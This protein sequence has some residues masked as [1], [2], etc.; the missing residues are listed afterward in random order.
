MPWYRLESPPVEHGDEE[1][2]E[3]FEEQFGLAWSPGDDPSRHPF[4]FADVSAP[5]RADMLT[6]RHQLLLDAFIYHEYDTVRVRFDYGGDEGLV[7]FVSATS[8][9]RVDSATTALDTIAVYLD[10]D[11]DQN[12]DHCGL[13]ASMAAVER[14]ISDLYWDLIG[15]GQTGA[16]HVYGTFD[17]D[18]EKFAVVDVQGAPRWR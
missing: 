5:L 8:G 7:Q 13:A 14:M 3:R 2:L 17:L 6:R 11:L 1:N 18:L 9:D 15:F 16:H 12:S 4:R 10:G